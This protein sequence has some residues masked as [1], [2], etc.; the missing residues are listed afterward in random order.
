MSTKKIKLINFL[1]EKA[2]LASY[3]EIIKAEFNKVFYLRI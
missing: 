1:K 2:G 3:R